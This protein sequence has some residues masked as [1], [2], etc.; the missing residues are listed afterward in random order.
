MRRHMNLIQ[1]ILEYTEEHGN[2]KILPL[3]RFEE[4]TFAQVNYH[5][6]LCGQAGYLELSVQ[7][8]TVG[9]PRKYFILELTWKG[10][11]E[12]ARMRGE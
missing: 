2:G 9:E 12:L 7:G 11:E 5:T 4:Y 10:H 8:K 6:G 3:P 1:L